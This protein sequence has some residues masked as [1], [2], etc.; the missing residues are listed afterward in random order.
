MTTRPLT[1]GRIVYDR[2]TS[3]PIRVDEVHTVERE[4]TVIDGE[5][6]PAAT[7]TYVEASFLGDEFDLLGT[8]VRHTDDLAGVVA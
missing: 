5:A 4:A 1:A 2:I 3:Q 7:D 6:L 8:A